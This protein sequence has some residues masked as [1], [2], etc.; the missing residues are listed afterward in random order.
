MKDRILIVDD[1]KNTRDFMA[2]A[3]SYKYEVLTAAD[4]ELAMK[5]LDADRSIRLP[6]PMCVCQVRMALRS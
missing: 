3:L 4:A 6:C 2:R 1:E 5:Q